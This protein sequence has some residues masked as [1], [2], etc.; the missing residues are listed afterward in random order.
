MFEKGRVVE[1]GSFDDLIRTNGRF[2]ELARAQY[3]VPEIGTSR[4][5]AA[6]PQ[7]AEA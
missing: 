6:M 5:R 4:P 7:E 1:D 3:L 2:A